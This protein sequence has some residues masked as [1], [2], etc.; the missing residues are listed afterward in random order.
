MINAVLPVPVQK[1]S[2]VMMLNENDE[3]LFFS[4]LWVV[5]FTHYYFAAGNCS[6][7]RKRRFSVR[8]LLSVLMGHCLHRNNL[9]NL[10]I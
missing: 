3:V 1:V 7:R 5:W 9:N 8:F 10:M 6:G 2:K 4:L